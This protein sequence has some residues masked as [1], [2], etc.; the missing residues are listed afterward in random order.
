[1]QSDTPRDID[2]NEIKRLILL[3]SK[4]QLKMDIDNTLVNMIK[5]NVNSSAIIDW[6]QRKHIKL[7][8]RH[9]FEIS[10]HYKS[11]DLLKYVIEQGVQP[12]EYILL[13]TICDENQPEESIIFLLNLGVPCSSYCTN[14]AKSREIPLSAETMKKL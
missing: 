6:I 7:N 2:Y 5:E 14:A 11:F 13:H 1:M 12:S 10:C 9:L 8:H 3:G 4:R